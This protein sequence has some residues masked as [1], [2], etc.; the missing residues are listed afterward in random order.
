M[1]A[2]RRLFIQVAT[3]APQTFVDVQ[4]AGFGNTSSATVPALSGL[5]VGDAM[6][7]IVHKSHD[8]ATVT[9]P[10]GWMQIAAPGPDPTAL[11]STSGFRPNQGWVFT[12]TAVS[13]DVGATVTV[14]VSIGVSVGQA[15]V[16][17]YRPAGSPIRDV[18][19]T[20]TSG[21]QTGSLDRTNNLV[22]LTPT[23]PPERVFTVWFAHRTDGVSAAATLTPPAA[24]TTRL[25]DSR[26]GSSTGSYAMAICDE[27]LSTA[28]TSQ[29]CSSNATST[30]CALSVALTPA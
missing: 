14:S 5:A 2:A 8:T 10:A 28:L 24:M 22:S 13:G 26:T 23:T 6:F 27:T 19:V 7:L 9:T 1:L 29:T 21:L 11:N 15:A 20:A 16:I 17:A 3:G 30:W 12:K 4:A 25:N 18:Q